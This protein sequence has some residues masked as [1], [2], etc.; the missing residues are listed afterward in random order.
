VAAPG[1]YDFARNAW[2]DGIG[3]VGVALTDLRPTELAPPPLRLRWKMVVNAMRWRLAERI[4][5]QM[6]PSSRGLGAAMITGHEAWIDQATEDRLRDAGLAHIISISGLHMA[7]VG[8]FVFFL[9]RTGIAAWPALALRV[10]GKKV[11]AV[12]GLLAIGG[13]LIVSGAPAPAQ[14]AAITAAIAFGAILVDRR[15]ISL[16]ALALAAFIVLL[17][18]PEAVAE[19]GFQMSFAATAALVAL[20]EAWP[21]RVSEINTPWPIRIVQRSIFWVWVSLCAS[22]VAG[23]ATGPFSIQHF[24]RV[25]VFGLPVNLITEP[26]SA[27]IVMPALALGG[28]LEPIGLGGPFLKAA[29]WGL[30]GMNAVAGLAANSPRAVWLV[31]SA[32]AAA[33]PVAFLGILWICL[34][35]GRVRWLGLPLAFA[36]TLWPRPEPP[37]AWIAPDGATAAIRV[38]DRAVLLRPTEKLFGAQLWANRRGLKIAQ[39]GEAVRDSHFDCGRTACR[40]V[41]D[42]APRLSMWWTLRKPKVADLDLLCESADILVLKAPVAVPPNCTQIL[43][44]TPADFARGGSVEVYPSKAGWRLQWAQPLRGQRPW[45]T[46]GGIEP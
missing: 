10:P 16:H 13:Y 31:A 40:S 32:P 5:S 20:A 43:V 34:W 6:S 15:A 23:L 45:T 27:F 1:A 21:A 2:F 38:A 33:L 28:F 35:R 25:A 41:A 3:G 39:E 18:Q 22:L 8:G 42:D 9:V 24:N 44:L 29:G 46:A 4:V 7:I 19:P 14:R 17:L 11:A 37:S 36:V 26:L 12:A 30:D